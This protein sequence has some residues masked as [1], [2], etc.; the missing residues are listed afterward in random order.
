MK[1]SSESMVQQSYLLQLPIKLPKVIRSTTKKFVSNN[2]LDGSQ[3][4]I[5]HPP[6]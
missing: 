2:E 5:G 6:A 1:M 3:F 4:Y